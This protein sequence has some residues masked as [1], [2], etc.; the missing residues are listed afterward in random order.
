[1]GF[2]CYNCGRR[3]GDPLSPYLFILAE[4]I[5]SL[6]IQNLIGSNTILRLSKVQ[7]TPCHLLYADDI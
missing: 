3:Q 6:N 1:M 5:L 2:F 4:E 7:N